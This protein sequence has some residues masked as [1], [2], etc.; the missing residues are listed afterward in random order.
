MTARV[1]VKSRLGVALLVLGVWQALAALYIPAKAQVGQRLL[2]RAWTQAVQGAAH[3]RPWP[4]ADTSPVAR[5]RAPAQGEDLIVLEGTSGRTL[6]FGPAFM[7]GSAAPGTEGTTVIVGHRDTHFAFLR[8]VQAGEV[9]ELERPRGATEHFVVRSA[10]VVDSRATR[11][12]IDASGR[13][14]VLVTCY[15]FDAVAPG[16]PLRYVV[17]AGWEQGRS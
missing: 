17:T 8:N 6:A 3:A 1:T 10:E 11:L 12:R 4:W 15:P 16:G 2:E 9:L 14:L 7:D 5:L 13:T